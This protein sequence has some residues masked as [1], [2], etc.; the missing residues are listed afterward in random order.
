MVT[1]LT[2]DRLFNLFLEYAECEV[3]SEVTR[4]VLSERRDFD[5][6]SLFRRIAPNDNGG[7]PKTQLK[8]F[9]NALG[10]YPTDYELDLLFS[11]LDKDQDQFIDWHEYLYCIMSKEL[12]AS[13]QYQ[14]GSY[15]EYTVELEHSLLRVFQQEMLNQKNLEEARRLL[16]SCNVNEAALF[17]YLDFDQ[18]GWIGYDDI[19][20]FIRSRHP[21]ITTAKVERAWRRLEPDKEDRI[22]YRNF[23]QSVRPWMIVKDLRR[24]NCN[25][26]SSMSENYDS[27]PMTQSSNKPV[28]FSSPIGE[29]KYNYIR[30]ER[31]E[32]RYES[33]EESYKQKIEDEIGEPY[34][35]GVEDSPIRKMKKVPKKYYSKNV[36]N[37][38]KLERDLE[39]SC[40]PPRLRGKKYGIEERVYFSN[41]QERRDVTEKYDQNVHQVRAS[42]T[43]NQDS[44]SRYV[45]KEEQAKN[46]ACENRVEE[47]P[48]RKNLIVNEEVIDG[49][50]NESDGFDQGVFQQEEN[51]VINKEIFN[52]SEKDLVKD[53]NNDNNGKRVESNVDNTNQSQS[54]NQIQKEK[55][56]SNEL[57]NNDI[58]INVDPNTQV[59]HEPRESNMENNKLDNSEISN[60]T[61]TYNGGSFYNRI[62]DRAIQEELNQ[63]DEEIQLNAEQQLETMKKPANQINTTSSPNFQAE[64]NIAPC[65]NVQPKRISSRQN[66]TSDKNENNNRQSNR[67]STSRQDLINSQKAIS[68]NSSQVLDKQKSVQSQNL[69]NNNSRVIES[70]RG[71]ANVIETQQ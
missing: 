58:N 61:M 27:G 68:Q 18:K 63:M 16:K 44:N 4:Q 67:R 5:A 38:E 53:S 39:D 41:A 66:S 70:N 48:T 15:K 69:S 31:N 11:Y 7:I 1:A 10:E 64:I 37:M 54:Q 50:Q 9:F 33:L 46:D 43:R 6:F 8:F 35:P 25:N 40:S 56:N 13:E 26:N 17:D 60:L 14:F 32:N 28:T 34:P 12:P 30:E 45:A 65:S 55:V 42:F 21:N 62:K 3:A 59:N 52:D 20:Y 57:E 36:E 23:V 19:E 2:E 71:S 51:E 29:D 24:F 49:V 47:S 22:G